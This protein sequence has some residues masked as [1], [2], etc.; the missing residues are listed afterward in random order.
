MIGVD[1]AGLPLRDHLHS[2]SLSEVRLVEATLQTIRVGR[3]HRAGRPRQK[4]RRPLAD[5]GTRAT[6]CASNWRRAA[7]S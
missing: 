6:P 1:G 2:A 5:R 7:S 4:P 3:R